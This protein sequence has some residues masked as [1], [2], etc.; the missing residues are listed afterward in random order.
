MNCSNCGAPLPA[1]SNTCKY[2]E[3]LNDVDLRAIDIRANSVEASTRICPRCSTNL[4]TMNVGGTKTLSIDRC[5][6]CM[7]IFFDNGELQSVLDDKVARV[8]EVD[9]QRIQKLSENE[10]QVS[11]HDETVR[12]IKCPECQK[13]MNR[14]VFGTRSGVIVDCC[15][16]HGVWLDAGELGQLLRWVKAGGRIYHDK[17]KEDEKRAAEVAKR[18]K[19]NVRL[20][21]AR[22]TGRNRW[23]GTDTSSL[24]GAGLAGVMRIVTDLLW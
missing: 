12:Y 13:V 11:K 19:S 18:V 17:R 14:R 22:Q 10:R 9:Y 15:R 16:E 23:Y 3:T 21:Q 8:Y 5:Q 6:N 1:K 24:D 20:N 2:C 4:V 7:G